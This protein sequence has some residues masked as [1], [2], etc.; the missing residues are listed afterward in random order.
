M[1]RNHITRGRTE[2]FSN[3]FNLC[4]WTHIY[5]LDLRNWSRQCQGEPTRQIS[6]SEVT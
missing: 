4:P 2:H 5:D 1:T 3:I 6:R